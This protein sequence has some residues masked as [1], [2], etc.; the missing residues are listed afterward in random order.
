MGKSF[1]HRIRIEAHAV[2]LAVRDPRTPL[3]AKAVGVLI[4]AY[5][6]SPIDLVPDFIPVLGLLDDALLIPAGVWLFSKLVPAELL[7]QH[8]AT[9]EAAAERPVSKSG[10]L[11]ILAIW[12]LLALLIYELMMLR[13]D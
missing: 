5:A 4:A 11:I 10:I 7:A 1:T 9:A 13:Y 8:R 6:L 12:A 3:L 2:W